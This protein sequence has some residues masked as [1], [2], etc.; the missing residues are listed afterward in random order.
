MK[1]KNAMRLLA[2]L[3]GC[4]LIL[5]SFGG[6]VLAFSP[7]EPDYE[8]EMFAYD[9]NDNGGAEIRRLKKPTEVVTI[10]A[11]LGGEPVLGFSWLFSGSEIVKEYRLEEGNLFLQEIDGILYNRTGTTLI[12]VPRGYEGELV[13]PEGVTSIGSSAV[14]GCSLITS[15]KFPQSLQTIG[16]DAFSGCNGLTSVEL[17]QGLRSL[18]E[19]AFFNCESL[20]EVSLPENIEKIGYRAFGLTPFYNNPQNW[21]N[22][23]LYM[24]KHLISAKDFKGTVCEI[25]ES[26]QVICPHAF[27]ELRV[28]LE[29]II[30][31]SS[32]KRI[33]R[34]AFYTVDPKGISLPD[35]G[36]EL[37]DG[38]FSEHENL[39]VPHVVAPPDAIGGHIF[40][41]GSLEV[42]EGVAYIPEGVRSIGYRALAAEHYDTLYIPASV[43]YIS[44]EPFGV[45]NISSNPFYIRTTVQRFEVDP[46]NPRYTAVDGVLYTKDMK[47]LVCCPNQKETLIVPEGVTHIAPSA[48]L[49]SD[50][51]NTLVL[52]SSLQEIGSQAFY[53]CPKLTEVELPEG[54]TKVSS[55]AFYACDNLKKINFPKSSNGLSLS[56]SPGVIVEIPAE[57]QDIPY[58]KDWK[59]ATFHV[60]D[61]S[62]AL[63][64]AQT[65]GIDY[66]VVG[67]A[68][69]LN[70]GDVNNDI[71]IDAKDALLV[72]KI[73]VGKIAPTQGQN[74]AADVNKDGQINAKDALEILKYAVG[75]PSVLDKKG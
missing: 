66:Q 51:L 63:E 1:M 43:E 45:E 13:I 49:M 38:I 64:Y 17:P 62:F 75:K 60:T 37:E 68:A 8:N 4:L 12:E 67:K 16:S 14:S 55:S 36:I 54:V 21:D 33:E 72:L 7:A 50:F 42:K 61:G 53:V 57:V 39:N 29:Q 74:A 59:N 35:V 20:E 32:V 3:L 6:S 18:G 9:V 47:T 44:S 71:K 52:P 70:P 73:S 28:V 19:D 65:F 23:M 34:G 56:L 41:M 11:F 25:R 31:P 10:P 40:K 58:T 22:G 27:R 69:Q 48:C 2:I 30:V 46:E 5:S 15:V 24:G 26:T